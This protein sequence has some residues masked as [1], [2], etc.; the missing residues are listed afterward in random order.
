MTGR[1]GVRVRGQLRPG[2]RPIEGITIEIVGPPADDW[3]GP[4]DRAP[5]LDPITEDTGYGVAAEYA[6][7]ASFDHRPTLPSWWRRLATRAG[8]RLRGAIAFV[9]RVFRRRLSAAD[10]W[11]QEVE[12]A[13]GIR[14][15]ADLVEAARVRA[16]IRELEAGAE[17][18]DVQRAA[19]RT[20]LLIHLR[21]ELQADSLV[22]A[23]LAYPAEVAARA[24]AE[25]W[26][27]ELDWL[28]ASAD[29]V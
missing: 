25:L 26:W 8:R 27:P 14:L 22:E 18:S 16:A 23:V 11:V 29:N 13:L 4:L 12:A 10:R 2:E 1:V 15:S 20:H 5:W 21:P 24:E 17:R 9:G 19:L 28:D 6:S 7:D 3:E